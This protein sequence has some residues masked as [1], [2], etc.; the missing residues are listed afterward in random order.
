MSHVFW[1]SLY[2]SKKSREIVKM[3]LEHMQI[4]RNATSDSA[5]LVHKTKLIQSGSTFI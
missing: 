1:D 4:E 3:L 5:N 2:I